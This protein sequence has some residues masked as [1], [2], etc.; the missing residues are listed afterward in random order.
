MSIQNYRG[1]LSSAQAAE[2]SVAALRNS[3]RL[4]HD[5]EMLFSAGRKP[6]AVAL[7]VLAAEEVTKARMIWLVVAAKTDDAR[8][9]AWKEIRSHKFKHG[10]LLHITRLLTE[11]GQLG[12]ALSIT[13]FDEAKLHGFYI[14]P[15]E[16]E[17]GF[18]WAEPDGGRFDGDL[19]QAIMSAVRRI[20]ELARA[21]G[22]REIELLAE[23]FSSDSEKDATAQLSLWIAAMEREGLD[24]HN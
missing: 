16:D 6:T 19:G 15:C 17:Q 24:P 10:P 12:D 7:A 4:L 5:A 13:A 3:K 1:A 11:S 2:G 21:C 23:Y 22:Q 18:Y 14:D 20:V 9:N 8:K